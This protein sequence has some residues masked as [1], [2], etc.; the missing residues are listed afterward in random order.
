ML[1]REKLQGSLCKMETDLFSPRG[2]LAREVDGWAQRHV[3]CWR[4]VPSA[5]VVVGV[6]S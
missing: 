3:G 4:G 2:C 1:G 5:A 6:D